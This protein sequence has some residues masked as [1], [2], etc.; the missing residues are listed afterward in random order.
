MHSTLA[1]VTFLLSSMILAA[2]KTPSSGSAVRE[3]DV[4]AFDGTAAPRDDSAA[5]NPVTIDPKLGE[6]LQ[7]E[8]ERLT[9]AI[10]NTIK[11]QI[12]HDYPATKRPARRD[13][14]PKAHGCVLAD[15]SVLDDPKT[16]ESLRFGLF[17]ERGQT[18][19]AWIRFSNGNP[20][21]ER[22]DKEGDGR[23]M[24]IKVTGV[25]GEKILP[26]E[27]TATTQDFIMIN[28]PVFFIDDLE[29]YVDVLKLLGADSF[30]AKAKL[31]KALGLKGSVIAEKILAKK[32]ASPLETR[33]WSMVPYRLGDDAHKTAIKFSAVPCAEPTRKVPSKPG[34]NYLREA[35][36]EQLAEND[37][38]FDFMVQPR[39]SDAMSVEDS[40]T[41]WKEKDA[42]F[43][44]VAKITIPHQVFS[45]PEQDKFCENLSYTPWHAL[46][47]HRPLGAINR[48]RRVVYEEISKLRHGLNGAP[49]TE[50]TGEEK[51]Q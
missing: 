27:K 8:E 47:E 31:A 38:C 15:F 2:C 16:P 39:T 25:S 23:G 24:A 11:D 3:D 36:I 26:A 43:Y 35:M 40:M 50:P 34:P 37:V 12:N 29:R 51:F 30:L 9:L 49:R 10:V 44:K 22:A 42:P 13:A 45:R 28:H 20:N 1:T 46:P 17:A 6:A 19:K 32:I 21:P 18:F 14:H 48:A 41:E 4:L 33:Y 7:P 5:A